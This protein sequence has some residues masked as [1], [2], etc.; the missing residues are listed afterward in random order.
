MVSC[1]RKEE[2]GSVRMF[3]YRTLEGFDLRFTLVKSQGNNLLSWVVSKCLLASSTWENANLHQ[4]CGLESII[5]IV[6]TD[7]Q[8]WLIR[9]IL[10]IYKTEEINIIC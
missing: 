6:D 3:F 8:N 5:I 1:T 9:E 10:L 4:F 7:R 2:Y